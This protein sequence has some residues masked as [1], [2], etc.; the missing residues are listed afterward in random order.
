MH[1]Y[2]SHRV[3]L[4]ALLISLLSHKVFACQCGGGGVSP[5]ASLS[6][7]S[8]IFLGTVE[9]VENRPLEEFLS[10][11][12]LRSAGSLRDQYAVFRDE[13]IVNFS[14]QETFK[15][16]N[17]Q[18]ISVRITK[19]SGSCGFEYKP[20][21][22]YF[23]QGKQYLVYAGSWYAGKWNDCL[24]TTRCSPTRLATEASREIEELRMLRDLPAPRIVGSYN[25]ARDYDNRVAASGQQITFESKGSRT[26]VQ[27][28]PDGRFSVPAVPPGTY[29][30]AAT[31]PSKY[32]IAWYASATAFRIRDHVPINPKTV[33]VKAGGCNEIELDAFPDGLISGTVVDAKGKPIGNVTVRLWRANNIADVENWWSWRATN[34]HGEFR[35]TNLPPG[36][37]V[38]GGYVWSPEQ[39]SLLIKG[40]RG[41]P[42][43]WFYPGVSDAKRAEVIPLQFA[44][45]RSGLRM[46]IPRIP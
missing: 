27:V 14:V 6:N 1:S 7:Y 4:S 26:T 21:E 29:D 13:I 23:A 8:S 28:Q 9:S 43:L 45:H 17:S 19:F 38:M 2:I 16:S 36:K 5:C 15:G 30:V 41:N 12:K 20:G 31:F 40:G 18:R 11:A 42:S 39:R 33:E 35:E 22:L 25:I 32:Q 24:G 10:F 34:D 46:R 44:Q 3:F 37:Y